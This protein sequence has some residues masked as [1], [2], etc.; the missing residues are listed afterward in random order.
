MIPTRIETH[1]VDPPATLVLEVA[2]ARRAV[3]RCG[4]W[5][6]SGTLDAYQD[7]VDRARREVYRIGQL[8]HRYWRQFHRP[9]D[10]DELIAA[11]MLTRREVA[12]TFAEQRSECL[13]L[14]TEPESGSA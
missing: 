14:L 2:A 11:T 8:E 6:V 3:A 13:R 10:D 1:V 9:V 7:A 4:R 5:P 12:R